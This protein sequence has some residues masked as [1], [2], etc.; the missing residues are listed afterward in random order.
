MVSFV[1]IYA[2][3]GGESH[4]EDLDIPFERADF[5][6]PAPPVLMSPS[7]PAAEY[8]FERV[9]PGWQGD[10]HPVPQRVLAVYLSGS[11]EMIASDG[12]VRELVSGTVLL[13]EDTT[14]KGH[15]SRV[16]GA[17]EMDVVI[18]MLPD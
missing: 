17:E 3:A 13:A 5:V 7:Q 18:L 16:T 11:G 9:H 10:W 2:D 8:S 12:E 1:R 4:F 15:M 14:G 6:P